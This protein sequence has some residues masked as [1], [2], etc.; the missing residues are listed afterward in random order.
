[1]NQVQ[2]RTQAERREA[3]RRALLDAV[4]DC[5][6]ELGYQKCSLGQI[7]KAAGMTTGAVQHHF[8]S[9]KELMQAVI[10]ERL[11]EPHHV[12]LVAHAQSTLEQ[13]CTFLVECYWSY[14]ANPRYVAIWEI[15]LAARHDEELMTSIKAWQTNSVREAEKFI[16]VLFS[17]L[18]I[19]QAK[20]KSLQYFL[21][22]QLRGLA[23]L[24][25]VEDRR[26]NTREQLRLLAQAVEQAIEGNSS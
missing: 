14:Y 6:L 2:K 8:P 7:A 15:I 24:S 22:S 23:L 12:D 20:L 1:M 17:E 26:F 16:R 21:T 9:R 10:S 13:R 4:V 5:L 3:T 11:F 25:S 18:K 19:T